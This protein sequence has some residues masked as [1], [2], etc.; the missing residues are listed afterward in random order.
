ME[1]KSM[2]YINRSISISIL[3]YVILGIGVHS[4]YAATCTKGQIKGLV[5]R[6][7]R[8]YL[9][10]SHS[11]Y[12]K[13]NKIDTERGERCFV[14]EKQAKAAGFFKLPESKPSQPGSSLQRR[15]TVPKP[16]GTTIQRKTPVRKMPATLG[17]P[18]PTPTPHVATPCRTKY[19]YIAASS[20]KM[21]DKAIMLKLQ[22]DMGA[23][24]ILIN[25]GK[26]IPLKGNLGVFIE[27]SKPL[28]GKIRIRIPG[29]L[30][31]VWTHLEAVS[32]QP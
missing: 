29:G 27:Q 32:C 17:R 23:L 15:Q 25:Q 5:S 30:G 19:G 6:E 4:G 20:E 28:R 31:T 9:L 2:K 21:F 13:I 7:L 14:T 8:Y 11:L 12:K 10:S 1:E 26:V 16:S 18:L 24:K 3:I 22:N